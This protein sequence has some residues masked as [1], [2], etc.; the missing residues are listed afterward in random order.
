MIRDFFFLCVQKPLYSTETYD[1]VVISLS[2][3]LVPKDLLEPLKACCVLQLQENERKLHRSLQEVKNVEF[4]LE[5]AAS[6]KKVHEY[7][8][9]FALIKIQF[10]YLPR[11]SQG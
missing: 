10:L 2:Y 9:K 4:E 5:E 11:I 7:P 6:R 3:S 1:L 8:L